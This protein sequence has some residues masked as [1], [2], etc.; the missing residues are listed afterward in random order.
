MPNTTKPDE[1]DLRRWTVKELTKLDP[2]K[3]HTFSRHVIGTLVASRF[4]LGRCLLAIEATKT[5]V[6][7]GCSDAIHYAICNGVEEREA[8]DA[9]CLARHLERLQNSLRPPSWVKSAG[10]R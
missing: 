1:F 5:F 2:T 6:E 9:R 10:R 3:L 7:H 8:R 4:L